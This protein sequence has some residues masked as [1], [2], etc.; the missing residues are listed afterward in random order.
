M[1][2]YIIELHVTMVMQADSLEQAK[3]L[4]V[5]RIGKIVEVKDA[6]ITASFEC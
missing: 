5:T 6:R 3:L 4:A 2:D 1:N